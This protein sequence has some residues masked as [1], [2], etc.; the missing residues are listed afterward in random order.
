MKSQSINLGFA[1]SLESSAGKFT[2]AP[3][4]D[5]AKGNYDSYL[6]TGVHGNGSTKYIAGGLIV[7]NMWN[8]G[9]YYDGSFRAGKVK[10]DF[11]SD[12]ID[13]TGVFGRV[14]Y[15]TSATT[16]AGHLKLGKVF[17]LNKN[18]LLDV[19]TVQKAF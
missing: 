11:A 12:N 16:L 18:N 6:E 8:N 4:I 17:R 13:P 3:I 10:N 5:Y 1:R 7:R 2:I 9:F 15:D 19:Y 14:T